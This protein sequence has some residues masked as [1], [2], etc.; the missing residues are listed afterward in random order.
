[1]GA[2]HYQGGYFSG[3]RYNQFTKGWA[4]AGWGRVHYFERRGVGAAES[5]CGTMRAYAGRLMEPGNFPRCKLCLRKLPN[6]APP[7]KK[8]RP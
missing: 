6:D 5:V 8:S 7:R 3:G 4:L 2:E 1:M